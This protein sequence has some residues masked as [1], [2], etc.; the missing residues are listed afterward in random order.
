MNLLLHALG[1]RSALCLG[2]SLWGL[3]AIVWILT[4]THTD[5]TLAQPIPVPAATTN[6]YWAGYV[7]IGQGPYSSITATWT[8]PATTCGGTGPTSTAYTWIGVG[9][10]LEGLESP[11]IQAGTAVDCITGIPRYHAF[12]EWYPGIYATDFPLTIRP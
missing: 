9:G 2:L 12:Y 5:R 6:D 11:L 1:R 10:Y 4:G 7:V 3:A 8:V